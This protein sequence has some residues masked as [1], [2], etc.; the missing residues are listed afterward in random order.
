M[1]AKKWQAEVDSQLL[2]FTIADVGPTQAAEFLSA[3]RRNRTPKKGLVDSIAID[4]TE[5]M[6]RFNGDT[7]RFTSKG[8]LMDG[9]HR[10]RAIIASGVSVPMLIIT[11]FDPEV[12]D[13][14]DQGVTRTV[15]DILATHGVASKN[16]SLIASAAAI[17]VLGDRKLAA[18]TRDRKMVATF[19]EKNLRSLDETCIWAKKVSQA[20]PRTEISGHG[21][22]QRCLSPSPLAAL[23]IHMVRAGA[24]DE[25]VV[26]YFEKLV[27]LRAPVDQHEHESL[28][29]VRS[30][31]T[32]TR[33]LVRDGG[34]QFPRMMSVY[35]ALISSYNRMGRGEA[36]GR[37]RVAADVTF[38]FFDELPTPEL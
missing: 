16:M 33:P 4:M 19:V 12:M 9:Q 7:V 25:A 3:N 10:L 27:A 29:T 35:A 32:K 17:L 36:V 34:T 28:R 20:S 24:S 6:F 8:V 14:V 22:Q 37:I 11:G 15:V 1:R 30:W 31:L 38:K 2:Q 23:R 21:S 18:R 5:G 13:T 26:E